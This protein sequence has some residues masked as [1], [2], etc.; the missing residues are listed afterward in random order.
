[1]ETLDSYQTTKSDYY[2]HCYDLPP[3]LGGCQ[4]ESGSQAARDAVDG[5]AEGS[6][7]L[8]LTPDLG[9]FEPD[10]TWAGDEGEARKEAVERLTANHAS[11][12]SFACRGAGTKG[13]PRYSAPLADPNAE[14]NQALIPLVDTVLKVASGKMLAQDLDELSICDEAMTDMAAA[15][16]QSEDVSA[17]VVSSLTYLRDRVGVPRD[18]RLPAARQLRAHLNWAIDLCNSL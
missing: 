3:Q 12:V 7:S 10:W 4:I 18:M 9:G 6:W 2:T 15:L 5:I 17:Q 1:M 8:P 14:P 13:F 16:R 11:I